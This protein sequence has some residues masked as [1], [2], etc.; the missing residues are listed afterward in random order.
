[1]QDLYFFLLIF[2]TLT[3]IN[4]SSHNPSDVQVQSFNLNTSYESMKSVISIL[5]E[6]G[7]SKL[8]FLT[9]NNQDRTILQLLNSLIRESDGSYLSLTHKAVGSSFKDCSFE[10]CVSKGRFRNAQGTLIA[11]A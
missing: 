8:V 5:K 2:F 9:P 10:G 4:S 11:H 3:L 6:N 1:M 7:H